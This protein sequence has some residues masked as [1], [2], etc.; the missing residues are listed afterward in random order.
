MT[1]LQ[2]WQAVNQCENEK[3]LHDLIIQFAD[4][5]GMIQGRSRKF[6]ANKMANALQLFIEDE[7]PSNVFTREFGIRQQAIYLKHFSK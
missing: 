6:D 1:E 7:A 4:E 2:K 5:D 3:V